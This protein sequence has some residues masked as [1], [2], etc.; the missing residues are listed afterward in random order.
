MV[1]AS[2]LLDASGVKT[3]GACEKLNQT[4][5]KYRAVHARRN[6]VRSSL[7]VSTQV[8]NDSGFSSM[9]IHPSSVPQNQLTCSG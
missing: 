8:G 1:R 4:E 9:E 3:S 6:D 2:R 5:T 7:Q